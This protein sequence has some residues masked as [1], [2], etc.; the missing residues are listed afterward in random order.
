MQY[1][2][3]TAITIPTGR[4]S[5]AYGSYG[6]HMHPLQYG[7]PQSM[8]MYGQQ[9]VVYTMPG[10]GYGMAGGGY[11][12]AGGGYGMAGG[13]YG[14]PATYGMPSYGGYGMPM[15]TPQYM[16]G[17]GVGGSSVIV[18]EPYGYRGRRMSRRRRHSYSYGYR[19]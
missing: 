12:M 2:A 17:M 11:G 5:Y 15:T 13:G 1:P 3:T 18:Q 7:Y 4:N 10:G 14:M 8:P 6:S 9:Q 19:Y 16:P